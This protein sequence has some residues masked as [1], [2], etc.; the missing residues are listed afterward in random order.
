MKSRKSNN[1][2]SIN[3]QQIHVVGAI[4]QSINQEDSIG[5]YYDALSTPKC[6]EI[7]SCISDYL[8]DFYYLQDQQ[9]KLFISPREFLYKHWHHQIQKI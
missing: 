3:V 8:Q 7:E 1:Q 9:K 5:H 2:M 6:D 4:M